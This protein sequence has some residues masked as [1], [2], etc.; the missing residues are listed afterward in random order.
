MKTYDVP[1]VSSIFDQLGRLL[2]PEMAR[3][4]AGFRFDAKTQRRI[5]RLARK[6]NEGLLTDEER[7]E[8]ETYVRAIDLIAILQAHARASLKRQTA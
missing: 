8:Y 5:D 1:T 4:I 3:S 7:S 2:T 6:C